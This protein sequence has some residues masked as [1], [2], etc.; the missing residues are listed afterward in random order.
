MSSILTHHDYF[1]TSFHLPP[2]HTYLHILD[3]IKLLWSSHL[4]NCLYLLARIETTLSYVLNYIIIKGVSAGTQHLG[5][6]APTQHLGTCPAPS[7]PAACFTMSTFRT[8][9]RFSTMLTA[10]LSASR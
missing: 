2:V 5:T 10:F 3:C 1:K 8:F 4:E 6:S 9:N 7:A